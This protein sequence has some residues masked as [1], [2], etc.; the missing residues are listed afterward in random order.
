MSFA[1]VG[2]VVPLVVGAEAPFAAGEIA[3]ALSPRVG[4]VA[5]V[6]VVSPAVGDVV[7]AASE[8][9]WPVGFGSAFGSPVVAVVLG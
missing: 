8:V 6:P 2:V 5:V 4:A 3:F 1:V 7:A 9:Q